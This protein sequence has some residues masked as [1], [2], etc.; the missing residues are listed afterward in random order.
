MSCSLHDVIGLEERGVPTAAVRTEAFHDE[1]R[2]QTGVLGMP[3]YRM[4]EVPHP[5]QPLPRRQ[6]AELADE[7][8]EQIVT[9][10]TAS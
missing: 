3:R 4:V 2:E 5:I 7:V 8:V 1:E 9:R 6:V 10:L